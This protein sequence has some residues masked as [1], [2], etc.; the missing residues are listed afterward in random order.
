MDGISLHNPLQSQS[1]IE[2]KAAGQSPLRRCGKAASSKTLYKKEVEF[3]PTFELFGGGLPRLRLRDILRS[4][5]RRPLLPPL[6]LLDPLREP[7]RLWLR[8]RTPLRRPYRPARA[9]PARLRALDRDGERGEMDRRG[10]RDLDGV[11]DRAAGDLVRIRP[12]EGDREGIGLW[13]RRRRGQCEGRAVKVLRIS[14]LMQRE[15]CF[16]G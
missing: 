6:L 11:W 5:Y 2:E 10:E 14:V 15:L 12:R 9:E 3:K 4:L 13:W 8:P 16:L 7:P 1:T